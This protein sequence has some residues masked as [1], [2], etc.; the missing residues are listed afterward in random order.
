MSIVPS[1]ELCFREMTDYLEGKSVILS[2]ALLAYAGIAE[3]RAR[4]K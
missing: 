1:L 2:S 3:K 4:L